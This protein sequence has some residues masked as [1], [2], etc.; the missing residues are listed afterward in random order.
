MFAGFSFHDFCFFVH[1]ATPSCVITL[2]SPEWF[3]PFC[4]NY[5]HIVDCP[6]KDA[7]KRVLLLL[8]LLLLPLYR[9]DCQIKMA[10]S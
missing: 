5:T 3:L 2:K 7:I 9:L 10:V 1:F 8:F 6:G 4:C